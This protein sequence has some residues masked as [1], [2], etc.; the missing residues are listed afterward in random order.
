[1]VYFRFQR[2]K[3]IIG[4]LI[5]FICPVSM[6]SK[7]APSFIYG[8][9][10]GTGAAKTISGMPFQPEAIIIK[11]S[12]A[13]SSH[14]KISTMAANASKSWTSTGALVTDGI[15][16]I[17]SDGFTLGTNADV[18]TNGTTYY[19]VALDASTSVK[20]GTYTGNGGAGPVNISSGFSAMGKFNLI[21]PASTTSGVLQY[22]YDGTN[23]GHYICE[24]GGNNLTGGS[25]SA[26]GFDV[27]NARKDNLNT[28]VYHYISFMDVAGKSKIS[29]YTTNGADNRNITGVGFQPNFILIFKPGVPDIHMRTSINSADDAQYFEAN[30]NAANLIQSFA[31]DG[32]Q[33]GS[34][35]ANSP[36]LGINFPAT[37][38]AMGGGAGSGLPIELLHFD[39]SC[40]TDRKSVNLKW[41]TATEINN[42]YF[43]I[44]RSA[45]GIN[46]DPI[47]I[48]KG[49]GN[50]NKILDYQWTD[51]DMLSGKVNYY[52]L[53][54]TDYDGKSETFKPIPVRCNG[55]PL[56]FELNLV[57]N[58]LLEKFLMYDLNIDQDGLVQMEIVDVLGNL[59]KTE[60]FYH[61]RGID[62]YHLNVSELPQGIY[63]LRAT[64]NSRQQIVK[65]MR[66]R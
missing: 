56:V 49:A 17:N 45:D 4:L 64:S 53:K 18:N 66:T 8:S 5:C 44:E 43:T 51:N 23:E 9:Y 55:S 48:I 27:Y 37:Y 11:A 26:N 36:Y 54:Q 39:A 24:T 19:Y 20:V 3:V 31:A 22:T 13:L 41:A 7:A 38:M 29:T 1:M 10:T 2:A 62:R 59:I 32:F 52:R 6:I 46:F 40:T 30:A 25:P 47:A 58:P 33:L 60:P 61:R 21:I 34:G 14:F 65:F 42:D 50:S 35:T 15:T 63:W 12:T 28:V 57:Q 16:A